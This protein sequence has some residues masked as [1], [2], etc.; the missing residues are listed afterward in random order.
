MHATPPATPA[1]KTPGIA[2]LRQQL[3]Q[4]DA[5]RRK[6]LVA[7]FLQHT[8]DIGPLVE[9]L[10]SAASPETLNRIE[11]MLAKGGA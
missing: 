7:L 1:T 6:V 4:A 11:T 8:E 9:T 2:E 10:I 5:N 3:T